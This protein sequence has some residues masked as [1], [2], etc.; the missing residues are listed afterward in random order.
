MEPGKLSSIA[1]GCGLDDRVFESRQGLAR[2][3]LYD[4][5]SH[6]V[7]QIHFFQAEHRIQF[8]SGPMRF[9]DFSNHEKRAPRQE[10][11]K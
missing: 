6:R 10:I 9:L 3:E 11:S 7:L 5:C 1:L 2:S 4:G 8:I